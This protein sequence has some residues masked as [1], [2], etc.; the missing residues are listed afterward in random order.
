[1]QG[2]RRGL[3]PGA[4]AGFDVAKR[5]LSLSLGVRRRL[6]SQSRDSPNGP[7]NAPVTQ[8]ADE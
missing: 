4:R 3:R 8:P 7:P 6:E 5:A 1:V 2:P